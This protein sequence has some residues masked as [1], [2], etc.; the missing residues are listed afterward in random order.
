MLVKIE[1]RRRRGLQRMRWL[2]D[3][4]DLMVMSLSKLWEIAGDKEARLLQ[5]MGLKRLR[6]TRMSGWT[7]TSTQRGT[8]HFSLGFVL[9][10]GLISC[11]QFERRMWKRLF[12]HRKYRLPFCRSY[13]SA[14]GFPGGLVV[15]N[16]FISTRDMGSISGLGR[17][18]GRGNPVQYSCLGDPT[19]RGAWWMTF[20]EVTKE[21]N[22]T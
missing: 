2:D 7:T 12:C 10:I 18:P 13:K 19:E 16:L 3:I 8:G 11:S 4:T 15:K 14:I 21:V 5:S 22:M 17:S 20:H 9:K 1:G 6:A